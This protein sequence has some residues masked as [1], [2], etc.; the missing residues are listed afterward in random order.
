M[1]I[2]NEIWVEAEEDEE[3]S[4]ADEAYYTVYEMVKDK[5]PECEITR[6]KLSD[7]P[8]DHSFEKLCYCVIKDE[9]QDF[10]VRGFMIAAIDKKT[11][12]KCICYRSDNP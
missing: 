1:A 5:Y 9:W 10:I 6:G 2:D 3:I 12:S 7:I 8:N 11:H 4:P